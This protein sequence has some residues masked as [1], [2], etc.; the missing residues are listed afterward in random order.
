MVDHW[1]G[2]LL[3]TLDEQDLWDETVV[4]VTSGHGHFLGEHGWIGK[5]SAPDYNTLAHTPLLIWHPES[6]RM[7]E[8][9]DTLT[10]AVDLHPTILD[11]LDAPSSDTAHS[12]SL[13]LY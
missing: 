2:R 5:P 12:K 11:M 4:I 10:S 1:F 3:D 9:V 8:R 6:P 13:A 7:G